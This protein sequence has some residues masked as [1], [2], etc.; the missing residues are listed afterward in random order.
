MEQSSD[1]P[2]LIIHGQCYQISS[3][4]QFK[5][6]SQGHSSLAPQKRKIPNQCPISPKGE[7]PNQCPIGDEAERM[8]MASSKG[9]ISTNAPPQAKPMQ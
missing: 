6:V 9:K 1:H 5:S 3:K 4:Q 7:N 8:I 2:Y